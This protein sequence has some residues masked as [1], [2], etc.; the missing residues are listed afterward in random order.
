MA[1]F[2]VACVWTMVGTFEVEAESLGEA[3]TKVKN[4]DEPYDGITENEEC[5]SDS[6][7]VDEEQS[8]EL[9]KN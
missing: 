9:N 2:K 6:F 7:Q 4:G 8:R 3:I 5:L 1:T